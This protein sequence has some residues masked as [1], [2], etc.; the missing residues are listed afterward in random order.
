M[1]VTALNFNAKQNEGTKSLKFSISFD[2]IRSL[3]SKLVWAH[4]H[5]SALEIYLNPAPRNLCSIIFILFSDHPHKDN[6]IFVHLA[7]YFLLIYKSI[8][9][10]WP[11]ANLWERI[12][13]KNCA[14][15]YHAS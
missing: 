6:I 2:N 13:I 4:V 10:R 9:I 12:F 3:R 1:K 14:T 11:S 7:Q 8:P 5:F 15:L